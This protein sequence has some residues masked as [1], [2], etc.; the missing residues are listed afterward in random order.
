VKKDD[1][2]GFLFCGCHPSFDP[3]CSSFSV[4]TSC[5]IADH[6]QIFI[7]WESQDL[8]KDTRERKEKKTA[9]LLRTSSSWRDGGGGGSP[10]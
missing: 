7:Y 10:F 5:K 4:L 8:T 9:A 3:I 1:T 6:P 2:L